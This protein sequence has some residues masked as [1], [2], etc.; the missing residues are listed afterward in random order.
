MTVDH[1]GTIRVNKTVLTKVEARTRV[2]RMLAAKDQKVLYFDAHDKAPYG[3]AMEAMDLA[4]QGGVR[5]IA[6][7]TETVMKK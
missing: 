7:L 2:M 5:S 1:D 6:M 4:R 3:T